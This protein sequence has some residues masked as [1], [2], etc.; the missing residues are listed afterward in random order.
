MLRGF[1]GHGHGGT[2]D[3]GWF[4]ESWVQA[5]EGDDGAWMFPITDVSFGM[6]GDGNTGIV[7][8]EPGIDQGILC[9]P[10]AFG[11]VRSDVVKMWCPRLE[12]AFSC[13]VSFGAWEEKCAGQADGAC[14]DGMF[15]GDGSLLDEETP[16]LDLFGRFDHATVANVT[17]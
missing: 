13:E 14:D 2:L 12:G 3:S 5:D 11:T 9:R 6:R 15:G 1:R 17:L 7:N 10:Q 8:D 4:V 16:R